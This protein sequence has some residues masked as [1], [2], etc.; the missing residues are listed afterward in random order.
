MTTALVVGK[1][2]PLHRGHQRILDRAFQVADQVVVL[3]WAEPDFEFDSALRAC[4]VRE[5]YPEALVHVPSGAPQDSAPGETQRAFT[6]SVCRELGV[7][8][9]VVVSGE[10]YGDLLAEVLGATHERL[11]RSE[12]DVS[13][14]QIRSDVHAWR[15]M[16]DPVVYSHFVDKVVL[17]GAESTG[18]STLARTLAQRFSTTW[19][20]EWGR[21]HYEAKGGV[22]ALEDYVHIAHEHRRHEDEAARQANRYL[23]CDTNAVTTM[24]FSHLYERDSLEELRVLAD[25][26]RDRYCFVV[27]CDDDIA[28]E[29]DGWRDSEQW[30]SRMQ[31][32]V[33]SDLVVRGIPFVVASGSLDERV[34]TVESAL[35]GEIKP[36]LHPPYHTG[37]LGPR[38]VR[39]PSHETPSHSAS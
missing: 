35:R 33:I 17:L 23:F 16:L 25:E 7:H 4:W 28:F 6:E 29:Q 18:K 20:H 31:G 12:L 22:L 27:V 26:C 10:D 34:A 5:L 30:R 9:D 24:M 36:G 13:G 2:A 14:T 39:D 11:D 32:L 8:I 3:C 21:E 38:P 1:F 19:V 37:N 15:H